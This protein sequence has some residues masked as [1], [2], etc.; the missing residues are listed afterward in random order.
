MKA[1]LF[2][3][4]FKKII[5]II[6]RM[7]YNINRGKEECIFG[8]IEIHIEE[9]CAVQAPVCQVPGTA[10]LSLHFFELPKLPKTVSAERGMELW[11]ALFK[12]K[13]EEDLKK[14]EGMGVTV[15]NEAIVAYRHVSAS[16]EFLEM[17]RMRSKA[18]HDEAQAI[19]N[20]TLSGERRGERRSEKKWKSVVADKDAAILEKNAALAEKDAEIAR[21]RAQLENQ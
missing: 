1:P 9:R 13:T 14:I 21:L 5:D 11:L 3:T 6:S 7:R 4:N 2:F 20:A 12:A 17:E 18:L 8:Q 16:P 10:R 15:M 19:K